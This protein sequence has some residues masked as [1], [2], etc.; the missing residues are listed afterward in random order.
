MAKLTRDEKLAAE[1]AASFDRNRTALINRVND[2][3]RLRVVSVREMCGEGLTRDE[4]RLLWEADEV[5]RARKNLQRDLAR[6]AE[7]LTDDAARLERG[8]L[9]ENPAGYSDFRDLNADIAV[10]NY[11]LKAAVNAAWHA[12]I[13]VPELMPLRTVDQLNATLLALLSLRA[14]MV[15]TPENIVEVGN[16]VETLVREL[17]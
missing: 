4:Q 7:R 3:A 13:V 10:F 15:V 16:A 12:R 6:V 14:T 8:Q 5:V 9:S 11:R 1:A 2:L 17:A